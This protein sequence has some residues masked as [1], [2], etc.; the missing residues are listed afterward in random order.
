MP[1]RAGDTTSAV[2][3]MGGKNTRECITRWRQ[4][5]TI[6]CKTRGRCLLSRGA[7]RR[8]IGK[9]WHAVKDGHTGCRCHHNLTIGDT[10]QWIPSTI[11]RTSW[12]TVLGPWEFQTGAAGLS[13]VA[14]AESPEPGTPSSGYEMPCP[15]PVKALGNPNA[16]PG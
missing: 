8:R 16:Q 1:N 9:Y 11:A 12:N 4:R 5:K 15:E 10:R 3:D 6:E 7:A 2:S 14:T 13:T